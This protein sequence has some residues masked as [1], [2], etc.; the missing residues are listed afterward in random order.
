VER[1]TPPT[2]LLKGNNRISDLAILWAEVGGHV[3]RRRMVVFR[4]PE[5][6]P[7]KSYGSGKV[8]KKRKNPSKSSFI[9]WA[10]TCKNTNVQKNVRNQFFKS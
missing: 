7:V 2:W 10:L 5:L 8:E 9:T 6:Y 4:G 3:E 1:P